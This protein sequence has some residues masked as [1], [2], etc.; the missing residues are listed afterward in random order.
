[1]SVTTAVFHAARL[2]GAFRASSRA[3]SGRLT[4]LCYHGISLDDEHHFR[5]GLFMRPALFAERLDWLRANGYSVLPLAE[6]VERLR[7][8]RI[9]AKEVVITI[10]DGFHG[11]AAR[12]LPLLAERGFPVTL[13]VT[14][15]YVRWNHPIF[16][17]ALQYFFWRARDRV[18][19]L[20]GLAP[21]VAGAVRA[22]TPEGE[23]S[24]WAIIEAHG[25][26]LRRARAFPAAHA[27]DRT[28]DSGRCLV[29]GR[30]PAPHSP[31]PHAGGS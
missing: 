4:I 20:D 23:R 22:G 17:L 15:Y 5:P 6:A 30:H 26:F 2:T 25:I 9:R 16:R 1:V 14:T 12:G 21:G 19:E 11:T 8:G 29:G 7:A 28:G 27:D 31:P 3:T 13:Y 24:L 10:D 18:I